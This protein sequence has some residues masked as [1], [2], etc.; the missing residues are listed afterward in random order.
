MRLCGRGGQNPRLGRLGDVSQRD[1]T[2]VANP[3]EVQYIPVASQPAGTYYEG[4]PAQQGSTGL[5]DGFGA[6]I[7]SVAG[8]ALR[9]CNTGGGA[10]GANTEVPV[11]VPVG[12]DT[13][14]STSMAAN[15]MMASSNSDSVSSFINGVFGGATYGVVGSGGG[16]GSANDMLIESNA[17][18]AEN[19]ASLI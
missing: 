2:G 5:V 4:A 10:G 17:W 16:Y 11:V 1:C 13:T 7:G 6:L 8:A 12:V 15:D 18:G 3:T 19:A 9:S 14:G